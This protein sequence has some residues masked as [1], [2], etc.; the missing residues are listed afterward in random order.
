[1]Q[2]TFNCA[3]KNIRRINYS[4]SPSAPSL[5]YFKV[6]ENSVYF[7]LP[8][9]LPIALTWVIQKLLALQFSSVAQSCPTLSDPMDCSTPGLLVHHQ[10]PE[11]AETHVHQVGD[12]I[13]PS[14][15]LSSPSP[16]AFNL[17]QHQGLFKRVSSSHQVLPL[18]IY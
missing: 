8:F 7:G 12:T 6:L 18:N 16:P 11:L 13:Q 4:S 3:L 2:T 10:L 14:H 15:P 9:Q 1:M 17:S 5:H